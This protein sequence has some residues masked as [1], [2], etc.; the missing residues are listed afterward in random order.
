MGL[1]SESYSAWS[2]SL[3]PYWISPRLRRLSAQ[4]GHS[5]TRTALCCD[6]G[7][8]LLPRTVGLVVGVLGFLA[9]RYFLTS[10]AYF[11]HDAHRCALGP[12]MAGG[13][14]RSLWT[15]SNRFAF[16][17]SSLATLPS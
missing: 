14:T 8:C 1:A 16:S 11:P 9:R 12:S 7:L 3:A 4:S 6:L 2:S 5:A 17:Q 13:S 10:V 15:L